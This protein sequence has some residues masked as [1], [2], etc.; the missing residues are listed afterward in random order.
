MKRP[1]M[2]MVQRDLV[3]T[4]LVYY[5][6]PTNGSPEALVAR[7]QSLWRQTD[8]PIVLANCSECGGDSDARLPECPYCGEPGQAVAPPKDEALTAADGQPL[9]QPGATVADLDEAVARVARMDAQV[10]VSTYD[11]GLALRDIQERG[12]WR[13]R[14]DQYGLHRF[15][16]FYD[17]VE[18][19]IGLRRAAARRWIRVTEQFTREQVEE[20][21]VTRLAQALRFPVEEQPAF[22][23]EVVGKP[24]GEAAKVAR[25]KMRRRVRQ[26]HQKEVEA[27]K[28][29]SEGTEPSAPPDV[30][31]GAAESDP[32]PCP[33]PM[34]PQDGPEEYFDT[35]PLGWT[36]VP[37]WARPTIT[38]RRVDEPTVPAMSTEEDPW[39]RIQLR[40]DLHLRINTRQNDAGQLEAR[41]ELRRV[42]V[43][44][45]KHD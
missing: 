40:P 9:P 21:G 15:R 19:E 28:Q 35:L 25:T 17:F 8:P 41:V 2:G 20:M 23:A 45:S 16:S 10:G 4:Y 26:R 1:D 12:L 6:L 11:M 44:G 39:T 14:L 36:V 37:L 31:Q 5:R 29:A 30:A 43:V 22:L 3:A 38:D 27:R 32:T 24:S 34:F 33:W 42:P 18:E 13:L 7:L